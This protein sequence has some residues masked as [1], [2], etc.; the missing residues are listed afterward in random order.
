L[1]HAAMRGRGALSEAHGSMRQLA[2]NDPRSNERVDPL[3]KLPDAVAAAAKGDCMRGEFVGG[4]MG[5]L[6]APF[7]AAAV[8]M[9]NCKPQR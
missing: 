8:L 7:L 6:S 9:D 4:G 3:K 2:L 5:I 1:T